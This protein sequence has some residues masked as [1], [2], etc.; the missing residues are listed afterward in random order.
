MGSISVGEVELLSFFEVEPRIGE[1]G[2]PWPYNDFCYFVELGAFAVRFD[3]GPS[4]RDLS[5]SVNCNGTEFYKLTA[6][7]VEDV[8]HHN[9][10]DREL[11]E[12]VVTARESIF[13][14]L[15]PQVSIS[16]NVASAP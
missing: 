14:Q 13:L 10:P 4:Y 2:V 3:I 12:I 16:Q 8:R 1:A 15:R 6:L 9:H 5:L 11:L 7:S